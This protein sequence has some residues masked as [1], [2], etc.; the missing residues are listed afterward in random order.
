MIKDACT[1]FT[2]VMRFTVKIVG[3]QGSVSTQR[4]ILRGDFVRMDQGEKFRL[5]FENDWDVGATVKYVYDSQAVEKCEME[6][7][8]IM[9]HDQIITYES[10]GRGGGRLLEIN[11]TLH[12]TNPRPPIE[13][14][15]MF[16]NNDYNE[17]GSVINYGDT[18]DGAVIEGAVKDPM[19]DPD[20]SKRVIY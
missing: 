18:G 11:C 15:I 16:I 3:Y 13:K 20:I 8:S 10:T 17:D 1:T 7:N 4:P 14:Q 9:T 2:T 5:Y 12:T 6:P 19:K